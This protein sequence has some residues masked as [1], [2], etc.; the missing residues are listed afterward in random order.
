MIDRWVEILEKEKHKAEE[1]VRKANPD[2]KTLDLA[3]KEIDINATTVENF[4][5]Q[6]HKSGFV[7]NDDFS[8][9]EKDYNENESYRSL[10]NHIAHHI[11]EVR[12]NIPQQVEEGEFRPHYARMY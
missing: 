6:M 5:R 3:L 2:P 11:W 12:T 10:H 1:R 8:R 9:I 7:M 4:L